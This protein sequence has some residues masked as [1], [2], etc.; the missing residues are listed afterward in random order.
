[1]L[2]AVTLVAF[3]AIFD[4]ASVAFKGFFTYGVAIT[5]LLKLAGGVAGAVVAGGPKARA[6]EEAGS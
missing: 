1:M 3:Y 5:M 4:G 6:R 2:F